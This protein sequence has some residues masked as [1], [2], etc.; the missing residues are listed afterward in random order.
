[1]DSGLT[2]DHARFLETVVATGKYRDESD[3]LNQAVWFL[4]KRDQL[5]AE[6]DAARQQLNAGEAFASLRESRIY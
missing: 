1:M 6:L 4:Q 5:E 3:A 2:P